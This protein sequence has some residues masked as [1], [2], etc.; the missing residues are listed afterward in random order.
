MKR[1]LVDLVPVL[2]GFVMVAACGGSNGG[3]KDGATDT[4]S[5]DSPVSDSSGTSDGPGG[6]GD[7]G[8]GT[9]AGGGSDG[10]GGDVTIDPDAIVMI[11]CTGKA[12][13]TDC[14]GGSICV[15]ETCVSSRCGDGYRDPATGEDCEDGNAMSGDGCFNC[16]FECKVD[17]DCSD[18]NTCNGAET[19]DKSMAGKQMC[20]A[21]TPPAAG[22][23]CQ[24]EGGAGV[25]ASGTCV[26]AGCGNGVMDAGEQCDDMNADDND[27][28]TRACKFTCATDMECSDGNMCTGVETC[29]TT[30]HRCN[31]GTAVTCAAAGSCAAA[32]TCAPATGMCSYPDLDKDGR[33]CNTDCNDTDPAMVPG[34]FEC[35]DGKDNDCN[36]A[37]ADATAPGCE[38][39]VDGD[40]DGYAVNVTGA[41]AAPATCPV[42]YTRRK[43]EGMPNIDCAGRVASAN[44]AQTDFFPTS[45]CNLPLG[46]GCLGGRSFD[47]NCDTME[48]PF[49]STVAAATCVGAVRA[50]ILCLIR[51]GWVGTVP[52]CG[53]PGTYRQ[54]TY[55][56]GACSGT[57]IPNRTQECH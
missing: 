45:Y 17:M 50:P 40:R 12:N 7:T 3:V 39:Y 49:D 31:P 27:G 54:C 43:P 19:C 13:G 42:G 6:G 23:A 47:Y 55:S 20:T 15:G 36:A 34:G 16:R 51:S 10:T 52:A 22:S 24:V 53:M 44:P 30:T 25:C 2:F 41:I 46:T 57:D 28:C 11:D 33:A 26:K 38:C 18:A 8:G 1:P 14:G 32:G 56:A 35:K 29:N 4:G 9:D 21:G 5:K 48:T 37:T